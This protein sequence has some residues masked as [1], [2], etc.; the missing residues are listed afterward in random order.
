MTGKSEQIVMTLFGTRN[1]KE[2]SIEQL[3]ELVETYP[4]FNVGHY[5]L[6]KRLETD[7]NSESLNANLKTALYFNNPFWLQWL[8][9]NQKD[10]S[11]G[12]EEKA[13][14]YIIENREAF[15]FDYTNPRQSNN[16]ESPS[17]LYQAEPKLSGPNPEP[18][19]EKDAEKWFEAPVD[20]TTPPDQ[21]E[22]QGEPETLVTSNFLSDNLMQKTEA[23]DSNEL[24]LSTPANPDIQLLNEDTWEPPHIPMEDHSSDQPWTEKTS[25]PVSDL[26]SP[27]DENSETTSPHQQIYPSERTDSD[28][29]GHLIEETPNFEDEQQVT[30][31]FTESETIE[32]KGPELSKVSQADT[33][34]LENTQEL[35]EIPDKETAPVKPESEFIK[36]AMMWE[37]KPYSLSEEKPVVS[38]DATLSELQWQDALTQLRVLEMKAA[39]SQPHVPALQA[40]TESIGSD[41]S[42]SPKPVDN[43]DQSFHTERHV[44]DPEKTDTEG[45]TI[46]PIIFSKEE[47]IHEGVNLITFLQV[48]AGNLSDQPAE[49]A[50]VLQTD[51]EKPPL[52]EEHTFADTPASDFSDENTNPISIRHMEEFIIDPSAPTAETKTGVPV[53]FLPFTATPLLAEPEETPAPIENNR[54]EIPVENIPHTESN[55]NQD[56]VMAKENHQPSTPG[57]QNLPLETEIPAPV[58]LKEEVK[59]VLAPEDKK[60]VITNDE[61]PL[62]D[63]YH[64][65]DYFAS[66]GIK[67]VYQEN[68]NDKFG[69]QLKSFTDWLKIMKR[70]P[71][72]QVQAAIEQNM[73][74]S[75]IET[76][77]ATSLVEKDTLTE[78]MAAV[79]AKQGKNDKA[80][81][82]YQKLSLLNPSKNA[83]FAARIEELKTY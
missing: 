47:E 26:S 82:I 76:F 5:L 80:I 58:S 83:Y 78:T 56:P 21:I 67:F 35:T 28:G 32:M 77:A 42:E 36:A 81:E 20:P 40:Q 60:P 52:P 41:Y 61:P 9:E 22:F 7:K 37:N 33:G 70:L 13:D 59:P 79:L 25:V 51:E 71:Q 69:K 14:E 39:A 53:E 44:T 55:L 2:V 15:L 66:Q 45:E 18:E 29:D 16:W 64:T 65:I 11:T 38:D 50:G 74:S 57:I 34:Q 30:A 62:F 4:S 48:E 75:T 73:D 23:M 6:S 54:V 72:K 46:N 27:Y 12:N 8:L 1:L 63:P 49:V 68:P 31:A 24:E 3:K 10:E 43:I 17:S 19:Q